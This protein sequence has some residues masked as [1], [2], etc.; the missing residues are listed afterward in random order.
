MELILS[1]SK[2]SELWVGADSGARM[3]HVGKL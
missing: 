2:D 3:E 1:M